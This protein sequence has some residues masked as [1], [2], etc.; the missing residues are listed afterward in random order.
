MRVTSLLFLLLLIAIPAFANDLAGHEIP[1]QDLGEDLLIEMAA[2]TNSTQKFSVAGS[3]NATNGTADSNATNSGAIAAFMANSNSTEKSQEQEPTEST[4]NATAGT[5][6]TVAQQPANITRPAVTISDVNYI[7][8]LIEYKKL[9]VAL[10]KQNKELIELTT[11]VLPAVMPK[12]KASSKRRCN[13]AWPKVVS[14]QG[15]DGRLSA[16]LS[17]S[18][19]LETVHVGDKAGP[20]KIVSITP[21]KVLARANGRNIALKFKE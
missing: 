8:N 15:V 2:Q 11:P 5:E 18:A 1:D 16:T 3:T 6:K 14:I 10:A 21:R 4:A 13:P 20:G 17:S 7:R 19:G 9:E 12:T